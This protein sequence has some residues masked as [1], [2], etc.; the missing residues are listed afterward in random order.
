M[1]VV[2]KVKLFNDLMWLMS[3]GVIG[4]DVREGRPGFLGVGTTLTY[5]HLTLVL[6]LILI[7]DREHRTITT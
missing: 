1:V 3:V 4:L 2:E 7:L 6:V 5:T